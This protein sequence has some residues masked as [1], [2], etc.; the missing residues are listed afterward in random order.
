MLAVLAALARLSAPFCELAC[1]PLGLFGILESPSVLMELLGSLP[2]YAESVGPGLRPPSGAPPGAACMSGTVTA[3]PVLPLSLENT[4]HL[5]RFSL[6]CVAGNI[7]AVG[8]WFHGGWRTI[9][10]KQEEGKIRAFIAR[11]KKIGKSWPMS[12]RITA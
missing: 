12:S 2:P 4:F 9:F 1:K 3:S 7:I 5:G 10:H 6:V 11:I 8:W